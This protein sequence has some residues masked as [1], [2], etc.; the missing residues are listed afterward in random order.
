LL[1][2]YFVAVVTITDFLNVRLGVE[3]MTLVVVLAAVMIS[4][5]G[6]VFVHDWWFFLLG[7]VMWNL[8][9]PIAASSPLHPHLE[10]LLQLDRGMFFGR[11]PVVI[12]QHALATPG[13]IGP[14]DLLTSAAYNLHVPEPYIAG[15]FLWRLDRSLYLQ[16]TSA[17]LILLVAG[18]VTFVV[19]PAVPPWMASTWYGRLPHVFNGFGPVLRAHPLPFHG[20]PMFKVFDLHGDAVAAFPSEHAAF[21]LLE[22]LFAWRLSRRV[23]LLLLLWVGWVFFSVVYLGEH[24]ITDV[25]AGW[26]YALAVFWIVRW[27]A[28]RPANAKGGTRRKSV[29]IPQYN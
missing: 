12:V 21:P 19:F 18:F 11:N 29:T 3:L 24:W 2:V 17:I 10:L 27:I 15:Y 20:S 7:L 14:L 6:A 13:H 4:R 23:S 8:S 9:G 5:A 16:F 25:I 26:I 1:A 22:C 28:S